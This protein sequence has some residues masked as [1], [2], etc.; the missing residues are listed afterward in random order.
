MR[1]TM[2]TE[3]QAWLQADPAGAG[4]R[5]PADDIIEYTLSKMQARLDGIAGHSGQERNGLLFTGNIHDAYPRGL[6]LDMR[7]SPLDKM[8]WIMIRQY[9]LQNDG[10]IFPSYDELQK[11]LASPASGLAS[12]DTVSRA[13]TMLRLTGWLSLC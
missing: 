8:C 4:H 3:S 12:R 6:I 11:L 13:L 2:Q 7:L 9:A 5:L 10:A 1:R